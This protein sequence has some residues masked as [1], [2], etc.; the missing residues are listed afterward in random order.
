MLPW[1]VSVLE[2]STDDFKLTPNFIPC[3]WYLATSTTAFFHISFSLSSFLPPSSHC[4]PIALKRRWNMK[5]SLIFSF[6]FSTKTF[7]I[8]FFQHF[9][10]SLPV[11]LRQ[12]SGTAIRTT[13]TTRTITITRLRFSNC[14]SSHPSP[15]PSEYLRITMWFCHVMLRT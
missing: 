4:Y 15:I 9:W 10:Q 11:A 13:T 8:S 2:S 7:F 3:Q 6:L 5:L 1:D 14:Q 12:H